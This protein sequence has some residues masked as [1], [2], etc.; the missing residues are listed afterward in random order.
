M[1]K[2]GNKIIINNSMQSHYLGS[3]IIIKGRRF[4]NYRKIICKIVAKRS[5][6]GSSVTLSGLWGTNRRAEGVGSGETQVD[7]K[8]AQHLRTTPLA[9][10]MSTIFAPDLPEPVIDWTGSGEGVGRGNCKSR[11]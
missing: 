7:G 4:I 8:R 11:L 5:K 10:D 2:L 9:A 6:M 3:K 1:G